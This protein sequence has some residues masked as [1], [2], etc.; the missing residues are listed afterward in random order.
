ME[1]TVPCNSRLQKLIRPTMKMQCVASSRRSPMSIPHKPPKVITSNRTTLPSSSS[2]VH[3]QTMSDIMSGSA[4]ARNAASVT[5]ASQYQSALSSHPRN[6]FWS[7]AAEV[8]VR[9]GGAT[10]DNRAGLVSGNSGSASCCPCERSCDDMD[11]CRDLNKE[12]WDRRTAQKK[13]GTARR[14]ESS[15]IA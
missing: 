7:G 1:K 13:V 9:S 11:G 8:W 6:L 2:A 4:N 12:S 14:P 10:F 15:L 3:E 5:I